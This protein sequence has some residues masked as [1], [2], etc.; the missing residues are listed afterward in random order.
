MLANAK[1]AAASSSG[2]GPKS[3]VQKLLEGRDETDTVQLSPVAKLLAA[4]NTTAAK[5]TSYFDSDEYI[6]AKV[7]QLK[8]QL[9]LYSTLPGLDPSGGVLDSLTKQVNDLVKKQQAK[10][11][12]T[13]AEA[14][15]KQEELAK[16]QANEYKGY[17]SKDLLSR[18]K[19]L[20]T[21]GKISTPI[22][23]EAQALIDKVNTTA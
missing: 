10:L 12:A 17:S 23:A 22:S 21:T 16:A 8:Q 9:N 1:A 7:S 4:Q 18:S 20:A 6:T 5:S 19:E 15:A 2:T 11:K 3:A 13:Q 14:A